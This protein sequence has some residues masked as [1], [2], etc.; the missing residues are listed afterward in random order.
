M[1]KLKLET[2]PHLNP[3]Q[4]SWLK[5]GSEVKVSKRCL[6]NFSI[7]SKYKDKV[8]C[9]VVTMDAC[10]LLWEDLGN[11][12]KM[13]ITMLVRI[14]I[15]FHRTTRELFLHHQRI[16]CLSQLMEEVLTFLISVSLSEKWS[17]LIWFMC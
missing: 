17:I 10:H 14:L 2:S 1:D 12:I 3:Y 4:L 11:M 13:Y 8:W 16:S 6:V 7:A 9:D 15:V 5:K